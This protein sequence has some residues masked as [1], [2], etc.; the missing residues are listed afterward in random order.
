MQRIGRICTLTWG[1]SQ[2]TDEYWQVDKLIPE[3]L[4]PA[5]N[6]YTPA[7]A[8][9]SDGYV[10]N[11]CAYCFVGNDGTVGFKVAGAMSGAIN[12][13]NCSWAIG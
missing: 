5:G 1:V 3:E 2:P 7:C 9:D 11:V 6:V 8:T 10:L 12:N 4:R 13:G